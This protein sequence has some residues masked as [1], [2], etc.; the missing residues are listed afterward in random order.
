[1]SAFIVSDETMQKIGH[2][3]RE[4]LDVPIEEVRELVPELRAMN[5]RAVVERYDENADEYSGDNPIIYD[6]TPAPGEPILLSAE[7]YAAPP[8]RAALLKML[9][10]LHY[11]CIQGDVPQED[12]FAKLEE[13][14]HTVENAIATSTREYEA[15]P[16]G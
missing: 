11:Q 9:H 13:W 2:G 7:M 10:C 3:L 4:I 15:A 8:E 1:M 16:W 6:P 14:A 5:I 12:L